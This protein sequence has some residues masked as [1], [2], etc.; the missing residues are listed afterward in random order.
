MTRFSPRPLFVKARYSTGAVCPRVGLA[1]GRDKLGGLAFM[2]L[3]YNARAIHFICLYILLYLAQISSLSIAFLI[4][5]FIGLGMFKLA[6][7]VGWKER[8]GVRRPGIK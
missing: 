3:P 1:T 5:G 8:W 2:A 7:D 6:R 4:V